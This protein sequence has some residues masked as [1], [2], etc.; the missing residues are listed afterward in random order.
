MKKYFDKLMHF[1]VSAFLVALLATFLPILWAAVV[2]FIIGVIKEVWDNFCEGNRFDWYDI[3]ADLAGVVA[4][5]MLW[6][7]S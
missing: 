7:F 4:G 2:A 5:A 1:F 3:L 6:Q